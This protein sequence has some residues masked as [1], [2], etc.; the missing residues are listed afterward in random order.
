MKHIFLFTA[1]FLGLNSFS[2]SLQPQ[3][4]ANGG[5]SYSNA[6]GQLDWTIGEPV[7][8]TLSS[9]NSISQGFH[10]PDLSITTGMAT[11]EL[12][13]I[14]I[15]PNPTVSAINLQ[16]ENIKKNASVELYDA[17]GKLVYTTAVTPAMQIDMTNMPKGTYLLTV[18]ENNKRTRTAQVIKN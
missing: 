2:Q 5:T 8:A 13:G 11:E 17:A 18:I 9:G 15:Y 4:I 7:T 10:Q 16:F 3:A 14:S 1:L 6:S 12:D